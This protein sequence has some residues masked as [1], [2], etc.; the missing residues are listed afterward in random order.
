M[1]KLSYGSYKCCITYVLL[2]SIM[3]ICVAQH[4]GRQPNQD[5]K[6]TNLDETGLTV[7]GCRHTVAQKAVNMFR[8]EMYV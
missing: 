1:K 2:C 8:G 4:G 3:T 5:K 6:L 7:A